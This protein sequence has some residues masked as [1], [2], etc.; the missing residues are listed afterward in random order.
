MPT[1]KTVPIPP[2]IIREVDDP[3]RPYTDYDL[4]HYL[5]KEKKLAQLDM[6]EML[7]CGITCIRN[8][9]NKLG[10][11][12]RSLSEA[13][14]LAKDH[15]HIAPL[16]DGPNGYELWSPSLGDGSRHY[17]YV[18]R[19]LA[20]SIWGFDAVCDMHV[21]HGAGD[22]PTEIPWDN[23]PDNLKLMTNSDHQKAHSK[24]SW[25]QKVE[26][27]KRYS[28]EDTSTRKLAEDYPVSATTILN[29]IH[30]VRES[31]EVVVEELEQG[32]LSEWAS[33]N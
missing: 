4:M 6:A 19:L 9:L 29:A 21:H 3:E 18:H 11:E 1:R 27:E 23:R 17:V 26:I 20:V 25:E 13:M 32:T 24:L 16:R 2:K 31:K 30:E 15:P 22:H 28:T 12:R 10:I 14:E 7:P 5:Y 33:A 8:W